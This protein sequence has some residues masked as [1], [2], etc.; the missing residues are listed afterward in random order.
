M[1]LNDYLNKFGVKVSEFSF[2]TKIPLNSI[3]RWK[4][5]NKRPIDI[6]VKIIEKYTKNNVT[7]E[8][9]E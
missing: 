7:S 1:K 9:W 8:D 2:A 3:Y 6:Y 5:S 4:R